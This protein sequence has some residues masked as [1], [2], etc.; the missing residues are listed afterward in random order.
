MLR[1]FFL[2]LIAIS[3][4]F[5]AS[6]EDN[7]KSLLESQGAKVSIIETIT[8]KDS[9]DL[10]LTI[11]EI[12]SNAQRVPLFATKDG[13][14]IIGLSNIFFTKSSSDEAAIK[15]ALDSAMKYNEN[16]QKIAAGK[17]IGA[18]K[19]EQYITLKSAAK[20]PKTMFIVADPN[21]GYCREEFKKIDTRLKTHNVNII[22]VGVLGE[23]SMKK[24]AHLVNNTTSAMSERDKMS[25]LRE[26]FSNNFKTPISVDTKAVEATTEFL[27]ASGVIRGVPFIYEAE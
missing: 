12:D 2:A 5:A 23:D 27:F 22:M 7:V 20:N 13:N 10:V 15:K 8:L 11:V 6:F 4:A 16:S 1:V 25:A 14:T 24:A 3:G 9:K 26:I 17:L 18:L 19:P 21:C